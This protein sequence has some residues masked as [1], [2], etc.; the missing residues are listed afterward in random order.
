MARG[1]ALTLVALA[2]ACGGGGGGNPTYTVSVSASAGGRVSATSL[3]VGGGATTSITVTPDTGY[4]IAVVNGCGGSLSGN[5]YTTGPINAACS[6]SATFSLN[7]YA[8]N[9]SVAGGAGAITGDATVAHGSTADFVLQPAAGHTL[10]SV[11]GCDGTLSGNTYTTGPITATCSIEAIFLLDTYTLTATTGPNGG[12]EPQSIVIEYGAS[13]SFTLTPDEGYEVIG[14]TGCAGQLLNEVYT[15][16]PA[17][18]PCEVE[19]TFALKTYVITSSAGPNGNIVPGSVTI[20]HGSIASFIVVPDEGYSIASAIGCGGALDGNVYTTG[21]ITG[22]C[23]VEVAF[24][25]NTYEVTVVSG[26]N[27]RVEPEIAIV[28]HGSTADFV[29]S[30]DPGFLIDTVSGCGGQLVGD[31]YTTGPI[32]GPCALSASF[33]HP[34]VSGVLV[35][36]PGSDSDSDVNDWNAPYTW[37]GSVQTAQYIRGRGTVGG[38]ANVGGQGPDGRSYTY[39]D[40]WDI[41]RAALSAGDEITLRIESDTSDLDLYLADLGG[42]IIDAS[43]GT[44]QTETLTVSQSGEFLIAVYAY[45]GA[46]NYMVTIDSAAA[47]AQFTPRLSDAFTAGEAVVRFVPG[48][49]SL[50]MRQS[51]LAALPA[52]RPADRSSLIRFEPT[53]SLSATSTPNADPDCG[54]TEQLTFADAESSAKLRTLCSLKVLLRDP[55]IAVAEPNYLYELQQFTPDD[56]LFPNQW[57]YIQ[58]GLPEAWLGTM[59]AGA[60]VAV[61]DSGVYTEHPDLQPQL[62]DGYDFVLNQLGGEDPNP[63]SH[64]THV[65]G[66]IAAAT[67]NGIGVAGVAFQATLM[68]LRVCQGSCSSFAIEQAVRYAAGLANSSGTLPLETAD[69]INLS[70]G[71]SGTASVIEQATYDD[72]RAAG[73]VIVAAAGNSNLSS[74]H[75][76]AAYDGVI[77]VSSV[78]IDK[79]KA[80]Y[81][82]FGPWIDVAAPGGQAI[83]DS[84]GDGYLDGVL[85]TYGVDEAGDGT[86]VHDYEVLQGTSMASPHVAGVIALMRAAAPALTP[87]DIENMLRNGAISDD[88]GVS[89]RDDIFGNG[90]INASKAVAAAIS[91]DGQPV[92]LLPLLRIAPTLLDF[93]ATYDQRTVKLD[94]VGGEGT[95]ALGAPETDAEWVSVALSEGDGSLDTPDETVSFTITIDRTALGLGPHSALVTFPSNHNTAQVELFALVLETPTDDV[96]SL[97]VTLIDPDTEETRHSTMATRLDDGRYAFT[98]TDV[99][100]GY[101]RVTAGSDANNDLTVCSTAESCGR[102][103]AN[104][105]VG[106]IDVAAEDVVGVDFAVGYD[107]SA[108]DTTLTPTT[109]TP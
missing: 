64:G 75:Y 77:A 59:G 70:L 48:A 83:S 65:S 3:T 82:N 5:T 105:T 17:T 43:L 86:I 35:P 102:Y 16:A 8:V 103:P 79:S 11:T 99:A 60:V 69:V 20:Q 94:N 68:P 50:P 28:E 32:T 97:Y 51:T 26:E 98:I 88:L 95:I 22:E 54:A 10:L 7:T 89:G 56:P 6:V 42:F 13:T 30:P 81:S 38:Y 87:Q 15:T 61:V 78:G 45:S 107:L 67:N 36:M 49:D 66:T 58:I 25:I 57:H 12:I 53:S 84:D 44:T 52:R 31:V 33:R 23:A 9:T 14:V 34:T 109:P 63:N 90:L 62:I 92:P 39:G 40:V 71:R 18:G 74:P 80:Y 47:L 91:W 24:V 101:Y 1:G 19:A 72:A 27:G 73:V 4:S 46:S 106:L 2:S 104:D 55:A 29:V 76:P 37:N 85:S 96:G 93:G 100:P 41:Y 108:F 21:V